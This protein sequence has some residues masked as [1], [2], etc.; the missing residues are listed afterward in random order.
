M[1]RSK[2]SEMKTH[3][4][5]YESQSHT[6]WYCVYHIVFIPKYRRKR[7]FQEIREYLG[8]VFHDLARQRECEIME[9]K[10]LLDHVHMM[11]AIPP[12]YSV[13]QVVG[14]IKGENGINITR[15]YM[16]KNRIFI[17]QGF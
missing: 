9:G 4:K 6:K 3:M 2:L 17:S 16:G 5:D 13:A 8:E 1:N 15:T 12:K 14:F 10:L 7:L 11:I